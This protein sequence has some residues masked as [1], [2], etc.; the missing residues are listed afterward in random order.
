MGRYAAAPFVHAVTDSL[1]S[2][3]THSL[4]LRVGTL[5]YRRFLSRENVRKQYVCAH[6][7]CPAILSESSTDHSI[8]QTFLLVS[9]LFVV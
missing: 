1:I 9:K 7:T 5:F 4:L 2:V 3:G 8:F 6:A